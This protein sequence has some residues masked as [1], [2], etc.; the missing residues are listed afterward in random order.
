MSDQ[1]RQRLGPVG[2]WLGALTR[3]PAAEERGAV[4]TIEDLGYG[5][6]WFGEAPAA[7]EIFAHAGVVLGDTERIVVASGIAGIYSRDATAANAGANTLGEAFPHRFV[8]GLGVSHL[9]AVQRRGH[10]YGRPVATM[11]AYLDAMD[12][13]EYHAAS[14]PEPVPRVLAAL[15]PRMLELAR[16]RSAGAHPYFVPVAHTARARALL[17]EGPLLAPEQTV[18]LETDP[19]RARATARTF[20]RTYLGL[21]NYVNNLRD[22]GYGDDDFADGGSDRLVDAI[23]AWGDEEAIATRVRAHHDVGADH[24]A[25]QPLAADVPHAVADLIRLAPALLGG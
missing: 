23:V 22:L 2:V 9:P 14:P 17:G 6:L 19:Q 16:E 20:M 18:V 24:V 10:V 3:A 21:P 4:L 12:A 13:A 25:I 5:A 1:L 11:R 8:L 15:G 7:K